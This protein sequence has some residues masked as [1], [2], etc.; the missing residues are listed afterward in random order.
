MKTVTECKAGS[1]FAPKT[2]GPETSFWADVFSQGS[3]EKQNQEE[4]YRYIERF[5]LRDWLTW[6]WRPWSATCEAEAQES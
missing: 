5:I 1:I 6:L 4:I 2:P 3:P